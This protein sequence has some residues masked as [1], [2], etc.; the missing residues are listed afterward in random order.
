[1]IRLSSP[2]GGG[3]FRRLLRAAPARCSVWGWPGAQGCAPLHEK[4]TAL[5]PDERS[6]AVGVKVPRTFSLLL[7]GAAGLRSPLP[8]IRPHAGPGGA[9][10]LILLAMISLLARPRQASLSR[11]VP[12]LVIRFSWPDGHQSS[13]EGLRRR[14]RLWGLRGHRWRRQPPHPNPRRFPWEGEGMVSKPPIGF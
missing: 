2:P 4:R 13:A 8:A 14:R 12:A 5:N 9:P 11:P 6:L 1:V 3:G 7:D 10:L